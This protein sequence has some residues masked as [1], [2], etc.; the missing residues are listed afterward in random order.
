MASAPVQLDK[1][2][3]T[4]SETRAADR[5]SRRAYG[6]SFSDC[7]RDAS[8]PTEGQKAAGEADKTVRHGPQEAS[9]VGADSA[10]VEN[11]HDC[12]EDVSGLVE[13]DTG[14]GSVN[15]EQE[16]SA[17]TETEAMPVTQEKESGYGESEKTTVALQATDESPGGQ[18][19]PTAESR[20][21]SPTSEDVPLRPVEVASIAETSELRVVEAT[22]EAGDSDAKVVPPAAPGVE[23]KATA[24]DA[25]A[26]REAA[27]TKDAPAFARLPE[28][29]SRSLA[30]TDP[31]DGPR[32]HDAQTEENLRA[33]APTAQASESIPRGEQADGSNSTSADREGNADNPA[34]QNDPAMTSDTPVE[35]ASA[36]QSAV[37]ER[38]M[39]PAEQAAAILAGRSTETSAPA[40]EGHRAT[41][42]EA[43]GART[44]DV[45]PAETAVRTPTQ[46]TVQRSE[47]SQAMA[48]DGARQAAEAART[49]ILSQARMQQRN[50]TTEVR[51][52][53]NP[54]ELG[55]VRVEIQ[56]REGA[57]GLRMRVENPEVREQLRDEVA[58]LT[59][60]LRDSGM[61]LSHAEVSDFA[62]GR[63]E[64][65]Q[66]ER[67]PSSVGVQG[68]GSVT[69][70]G[71]GE[72][73]PAVWTRFAGTHTVDCMV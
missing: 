37:G 57:M 38:P 8:L 73:G 9:G 64:R 46:P 6:V 67:W 58:G 41:A 59:R 72:Q 50:G 24:I 56:M 1:L 28:P 55:K 4:L 36:Q 25:E 45:V 15:A 43:K 66:T 18:L 13:L 7:L 33:I 17:L 21:E 31:P 53:L 2:L 20:T 65:R 35:T 32:P 68:Y 16:T 10:P 49:G 12:A 22:D 3:R 63:H 26:P 29:P 52:Q 14:G 23:M 27:E 40:G 47:V 5:P 30:E 71:T 62:S 70:A 48:Q 51:V 34:D 60:S 19:Q 11:E 54:P 44:A 39:E 42:V 61:D 69:E